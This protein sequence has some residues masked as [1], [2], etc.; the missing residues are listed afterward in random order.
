[1][2][3][4]QFG[5]T[6]QVKDSI[7]TAVA[8]NLILTVQLSRIPVISSIL[9]AA[10]FGSNGIAA[11]GSMLSVFA[12]NLGL[13]DQFSG[14]PN[15]NLN[16]VSV[17]FNGSQVP[18]F[19]LAASQNQINILAPE[20]LPESGTV[21]VKVTSPTGTSASFPLQMQPARPGIFRLRDPSDSNRT[22][23]LALLANTAWLAIPAGTATALKIPANCSDDA[24]NVQSSCGQPVR[25]GDVVQIYVTGFD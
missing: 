25:P 10:S 24:V 11:P 15:T 19:A 4:G 14:F 17:T 23:G 7:G 8:Q 1:M 13:K 3:A 2:Q 20:N 16:G 18:L 22:Y 21:D 6:T 12:S 9:N 5:F